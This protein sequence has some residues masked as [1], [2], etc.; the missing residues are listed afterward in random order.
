MWARCDRYKDKQITLRRTGG[1]ETTKGAP[2]VK[3]GR[4]ELEMSMS[5]RL[6]GHALGVALRD[7]L[8]ELDEGE[9]DF[10]GN[11]DMGHALVGFGLAEYVGPLISGESYRLRITNAARELL[12][13]L[14]YDLPRP[15]R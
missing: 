6:T 9:R 14:V 3:P 4:P 1:L 11:D 7:L 12:G 10:P 2:A 5:D 15:G 8:F 13:A